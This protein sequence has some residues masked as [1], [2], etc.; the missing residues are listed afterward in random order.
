MRRL[1]LPFLLVV[2]AACTAPGGAS[3][4]S[5]AP[6][7][8]SSPSASPTASPSPSPS[9]SPSGSPAAADP[10]AIVLRVEMVGG[11]VAPDSLL[12]RMPVQ[13]IYADGRVFEQGAIPEIYPGP[14]VPPTLVS[15]LT[16]DG[17]AVVQQTID[18]A[19]LVN[20]DYP[21]HGIADAPDTRVTAS[22]A[23]G[24]V[25]ITMGVA[26]PDASLSP[27]ETAQR[28]AV[29]TLLAKVGNLPALVGDQNISTAEPYSPTRCASSS[30]L[31]RSRT[32]ARTPSPSSGRSTRRSR[33]SGTR[34]ASG[35][36]AAAPLMV[37]TPSPCGPCSRLRSRTSTSRPTASSTCRPRGRS[38]PV[39]DQ[40][41]RQ[42]R[43]DPNGRRRGAAMC[44]VVARP[45]QRAS[46]PARA[47]ARAGRSPG[48]VAC[49]PTREYRVL[50][51]DG[52]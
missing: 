31:G 10:D 43:L 46:T 33:R 8:A 16:P 50:D 14:L 28:A 51:G 30:G 29:D 4:P 35:T 49:N 37:P 3:N 25:T 39:T 1:T 32:T 12:T 45:F 6:T 20:G 27:D 13:S 21:P 44:A 11:F 41:R 26:M 24:M 22:T 5:V 7:P 36:H 48:P 9:A 52:S 40:L 47:L 15:Q 19:N 34:R 17:L 23:N 38:S 2:V 42:H 18:A